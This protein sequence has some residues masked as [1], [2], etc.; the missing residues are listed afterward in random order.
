VATLAARHIEDG[1]RCFV[2]FATHELRGSITLQRTLA[3]VALADPGADAIALR[4]MGERVAAAC[5]RQERLLESLLTLTRSAYGQLRC[6]QVDLAAI[7][8]E[9]LVAHGHHG[10]RRAATL[11]P[12]WTAGDPELIDRLIAN[13]VTNAV[14]HNVRGGWI[15]LATRSVDGRALFR[16]A[17][18]GPV[19]P[20][21]EVARLFLP[22]HR[23]N[24]HVRPA[25]GGVGLGLAIV[26]AIADAHHA[27]VT[28]HARTTGG[29]RIDVAFPA[30]D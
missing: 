17:N 26:Q 1:D 2:A 15:E 18:T 19:I 28:P 16:I 21:G 7:V 13:L 29:L 14:R 4:Q 23:L 3:E 30:L 10:L 11:E 9:Q 12:A 8:A 6:E 24:P 27:T 20:T 5:V 22:F 25:A